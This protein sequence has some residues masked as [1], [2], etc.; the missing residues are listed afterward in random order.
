MKEDHHFI[1]SAGHPDLGNLGPP[2]TMAASQ[3]CAIRRQP[4]TYF[5]DPDTTSVREGK[6]EERSET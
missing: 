6:V 2:R 5:R 3:V 1:Q 4:I